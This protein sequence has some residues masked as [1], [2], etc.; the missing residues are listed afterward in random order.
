MP[1]AAVGQI[2]TRLNFERAGMRSLIM[3]TAREA[4]TFAPPY[5]QAFLM[6]PAIAGCTTTG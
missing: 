2:A 4:K 3:K 6:V 5:A 1:Q